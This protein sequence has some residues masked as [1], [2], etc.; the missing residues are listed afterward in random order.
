MS[1]VFTICETL[2]S[3][4]ISVASRV[5]ELLDRLDLAIPYTTRQRRSTE[6]DGFIFTSQD[7]FDRMIAR[8]EFL[9]YVQVLGNYYGTPR[10]CL[11]EARES[12]NDLLIR[13]DKLGAA[14]VKQQL[15]DAVSILVLQP[16]SGRPDSSTGAIA[17]ELRLKEG[18][19]DASRMTNP[20]DFDH[21]VS[22]E[23]SEENANRVAEIIRSERSRR[24]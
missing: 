1:T 9:E 5:C 13:V 20:G 3:G 6:E 8:G 19:R 7:A 11:Q 21:V 18:L 23:S 4:E 14:Q 17:N 22:D 2:E 15:P 24:A 16:S 12:G 10:H